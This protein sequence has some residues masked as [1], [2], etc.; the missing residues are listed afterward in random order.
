MGR[1]IERDAAGLTGP[2]RAR[3]KLDLER[4][5]AVV[6][7]ELKSEEAKARASEPE[8]EPMDAAELA[9][10]QGN[11]ALFVERARA[12]LRDVDDALAKIGT[13]RYGLSEKSGRPIGFDRLVALPWARFSADEE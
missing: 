6:L 13:G 2:Q 5:R 4:A 8:S 1:L 7:G 12:H 11:G 10:E 9:R 3:L